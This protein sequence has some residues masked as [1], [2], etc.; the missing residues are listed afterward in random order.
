MPLLS[1]HSR[2]AAAAMPTDATAAAIV[3][4]CND[5]E[6]MESVAAVASEGEETGQDNSCTMLL[7][8][9]STDIQNVTCRRRERALHCLCP[10][11]H[12][13]T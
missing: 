4:Q 2:S 7:D 6:R 8:D 12:Q 5:A 9:R 11:F 10:L 1:A 13:R 3:A